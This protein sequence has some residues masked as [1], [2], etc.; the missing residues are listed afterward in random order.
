MWA[1]LWLEGPKCGIE[2]KSSE[3]VCVYKSGSL[4][5]SE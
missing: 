5:I 4:L 2:P 3:S 1:Q